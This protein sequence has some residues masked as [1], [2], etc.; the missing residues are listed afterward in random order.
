VNVRLVGADALMP[1]VVAGT[2]PDV[3]LTMGSGDPVNYAMRHAAMDLTSFPDFEAVAGQFH[4]SALMPFRYAG[5]VYA[6]PETQR[7]HVMFYRTDILEEL[8][9]EPPETWTDL[10]RLLPVLQKNNM[11]AAVPTLASPAQAGQTD[12]AG[13]LAQLY[14]RSGTLYNAGGSRTVL[15]SA[16]AVAAFEAYTKFFTHYGT[17][18]SYDFVN[19]FRTGENPLGFAE[20]TNFNTLEVFAPEIRG[21]WKFGL[22][23][24]TRRADGS[25]DH[26]MSAVST[27]SIM[28]AGAKDP[29]AAWEFLRWWVSTETQTRFGREM[30]SIM[31]AAARYDTA[32]LAAFEQLAWKAGDLAVLK[33]QRGWAVGTPEVPGGYYAFRHI[34]NAARRVV[35]DSWET[36]E[37][38]LEYNRTINEE[39]I[40]KRKEFGLE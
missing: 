34:T 35:N 19:R 4:P 28:F 20:F 18:A 24:G 26:S 27:G 16:G 12:V 13:F 21:L 23:P 6:L 36:R 11:N 14:Q 2:G 5:G 25:I 33:E 39:L 3:A 10:I 40:K 32:N 15:D 7:F 8:G 9:V 30:E 31:G 17:P 37:T 1:A 29:G 22:L 38:L